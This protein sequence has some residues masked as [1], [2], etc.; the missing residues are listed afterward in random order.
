MSPEAWEYLDGQ[1]RG[2]TNFSEGKQG[3]ERHVGGIAFL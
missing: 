3:S 1:E 2:T